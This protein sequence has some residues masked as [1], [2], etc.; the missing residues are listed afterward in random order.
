VNQKIVNEN[1]HIAKGNYSYARSRADAA[2]RI[3]E[4]IIANLSQK[5]IKDWTNRNLRDII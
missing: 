1:M 5:K 2:G 3:L 4:K